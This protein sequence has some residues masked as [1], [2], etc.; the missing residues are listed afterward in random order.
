MSDEAGVPSELHVYKK[1]GHGY[2]LGRKGIDAAQWPARCVEW[3]KK[4]KIL[5]K[6]K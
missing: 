3:L 4:L 5:D 1:G 6:R 2:G